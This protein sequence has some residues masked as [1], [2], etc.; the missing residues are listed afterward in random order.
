MQLK[1]FMAPVKKMAA[2]LRGHELP[3]VKKEIV[4]D[5]ESSFSPGQR[6]WNDS[7]QKANSHQLAGAG[8]RQA[9]IVQVWKIA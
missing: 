2:L 8:R 6:Q 4:A 1:V 5:D 7:A 3:S 9:S